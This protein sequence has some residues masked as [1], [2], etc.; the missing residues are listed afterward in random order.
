MQVSRREFLWAATGAAANLASAARGAERTAWRD[1]PVGIPERTELDCVLV[2]LEGCCGLGESVAGYEAALATMDVRFVR[3]APH[4]SPPAPVVIVPGCARLDPRA[5]EKLAVALEPG[6]LLLLESGAAFAEPSDFAAHRRVLSSHFGVEVEAPFDLWPD[7]VT[8]G[9]AVRR[10]NCG[11]GCHPACSRT[12]VPYVDYAWPVPAKVRDFSR[13]VP[14]APAGSP[15]VGRPTYEVIGWADGRPMAARRAVGKGTL[16][17][18]GSPLGPALRSGDREAE[19][20][21]RSLL[22]AA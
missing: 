22:S 9:S 13:V 18:L 5:A 17:F 1:S 16:V 21:L 11:L 4:Q 7:R 14:L 10:E 6:S 12:R 8:E 20:W 2:D 3:R 15:A 19:R